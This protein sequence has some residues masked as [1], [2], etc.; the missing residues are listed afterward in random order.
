MHPHNFFLACIFDV[1]FYLQMTY[2]DMRDPA[3]C[4]RYAWGI[5]DGGKNL[6]ADFVQV[7][8]CARW[9]DYCPQKTY[10]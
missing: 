5:A 1:N 8:R 4:M 9:V 10:K 6:A 7:F 3:L 2:C